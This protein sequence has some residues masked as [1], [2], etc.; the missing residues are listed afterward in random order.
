MDD[1]EALLDSIKR[2]L[3]IREFHVIAVNRGDKALEVARNNPIDVAILDLKMPGMSGKDV[4]V[5]LKKAYPWLE[6]V[7]LTGHGSFDP[8]KEKVYDQAYTFLAK[9]CDLQTLLHVLVEAYK[10]TVMNKHKIALQDVESILK[11]PTMKSA[12]EVLQK[13]K[14]LDALSSNNMGGA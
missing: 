2:R 9:P 4:L 1:E 6:I 7:I 13:L 12:R 14:E 8:E 5:Q 11:T 10:K 3:Q